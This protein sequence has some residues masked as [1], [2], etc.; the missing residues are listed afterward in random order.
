MERKDG[1]ERKREPSVGSDR[2]E[3]G[4][5]RL[6]ELEPEIRAAAI[7]DDVGNVVGCL[8]PADRPGG[9]DWDRHGFGPAAV[10]L[11]VAIDEAGGKPFD[12]CHIA[13]SDAE[14][15]V[16]REGSLSLVALS[17]RFVLASL[18]AFDM[19]MTLRDLDGVTE[20]A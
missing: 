12:S 18:M 3:R 11:V 9:R 5:S 10:E 8:G 19:R 6:I 2:A 20:V 4:L 17:E 14:I 1:N 16:V 7:L 13:S 15:F